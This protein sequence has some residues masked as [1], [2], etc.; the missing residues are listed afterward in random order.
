MVER[1][2]SLVNTIESVNKARKNLKKGEKLED[3][4]TLEQY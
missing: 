1:Y 2:E 4:L 3:V